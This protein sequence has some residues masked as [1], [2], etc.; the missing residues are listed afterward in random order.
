MASAE[1]IR[2]KNLQES[3]EALAKAINL[4]S[5][6]ADVMKD[7]VS[8]TKNRGEMDKSSL[9]LSRQAVQ[10]T[11]NLKGEYNSISDVQKDIAKNQSKSQDIQ[12]Q[13]LAISQN[14][15]KGEK[16]AIE[17]FKK[18][19][20]EA[21][22]AQKLAESLADKQ[23][24]G[25]NISDSQVQRAKD[26]AAIKQEE[27][28]SAGAS[29]S[30]QAEQIINLEQ[31]QQLLAEN[32]RYLEEQAE[33]LKN[34]NSAQGLFG[35]SLE[36]ASKLL[37]KVG[38]GSS[39][40]GKAFSTAAAK[41]KEFAIKA[42]DGGKKSLGAMG[43][44][45]VAAKG[46]GAALT[47]SLGPISIITGLITTI[48]SA[49]NKG[50]DAA[51]RL[52]DETTGLSRTL[53]VS[54]STA[55]ELASEIR[56]I[57]AEMGITGGDAIA[58]AGS[59]YSALD[60][61]ERL[62]RNTLA[63]FTK[64]NKFAG[65]T[66]DDIANIQKFSKLAGKEGAIVAEEMA[67]TARESIKANKLNVSMRGLMQAVGKQSAI[68]KLNTK[69]SA[70]ELVKQVAQA[71]KLGLEMSKVEDIA[72]SLLDFESSI[73]AE[74]EAELLTGKE[75]NLEKAREAALNGDNA[76]LMDEIASQ[77]GSIE[78]FQNMNR[79]GQEAFAKS[80]GMSR[81][82]LA[83]MLVNSKENTSENDQ[84][85]A[86]QENSLKAMQ[87]MASTSERLAAAEEARANK[88]AKIFELLNPIVETFKELSTV[89]LDV[90]TPIVEVLA[91][92]LQDIANTIVPI[93]RDYFAKLTPIIETMMTALEP[94]FK[95]LAKLAETILP[96]IL[97][98]MEMMAE[99]FGVIFE[100]L[101]P[102]IDIIVEGITP[103]I[104]MFSELFHDLLTPIKKIF[105]ALKEPIQKIA[106]AIEPIFEMLGKV[107][108]KILPI[109]TTLIEGISDVLEPVIDLFSS[110]LETLLPPIIK[111]IEN[112]LDALMPIFDI[113]SELV[114]MLMPVLVSLFETVTPII[115]Q[116]FELISPVFDLIA[117]LAT[118]VLPL[119]V[120]LFEGIKPI[121]DPILK[122]VK[123]I[124]DVIT[125]IL[126]GDFSK[127]ADGL[128]AIAS[129][130][131]N[132]ILAAI[133]FIL[134]APIKTF[135]Y[136]LDYIP[137]FGPDTFPLVSLPRVEFA[138]GG[139]VDRPTNA[140][141]GEAGPEAVVPLNSDKSLNVFS[142][143]LEAKLDILIDAVQQ[144]GTVT[145]DGQKVGEALVM[146]SYQLK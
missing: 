73:A 48:V 112:T 105:E 34:I 89:V 133:E 38:L 82:G 35:K 3:N 8:S 30:L 42:T 97:A 51:K 26:M 75:L 4:T 102:I 61:S 37:N 123:G 101:A 138:E 145:L 46:F 5:Q 141:I 140:L 108:E 11:R 117:E 33:R 69:G 87:S 68:V 21:Q 18:K 40:I 85:L 16:D 146:S 15:S 13:V 53:G 32:A 80:I 130:L 86:M 83:E 106:K 52:S 45:K 118:A 41:T 29:L 64:L 126:E 98:P 65:F 44:L 23:K 71:K 1:E 121:L 136:M 129:G 6:L 137:G 56:G 10:V 78:E 50:K 57:G 7:V 2:K 77:F 72:G 88:F 31:Q 94:I 127:V 66:A 92:I 14:L 113:I 22:K 62:S 124:F 39:V 19:N 109:F 55:N 142:K 99:L 116:I 90:I 67:T 125:G 120:S 79:I 122:V 96:L 9:D 134:N 12:K 110:L 111:M 36:G 59:I 95:T 131:I 143:T 76:T 70:Q 63:T 81:D 43:K 107:V 20:T 144:G 114:D 60:G 119:V 27:V 17:A 54:K 115:E 139:M 25:L 103:I 49:F 93:I 132:S 104:D 74:M 58:A 84:M 24:Q 47:T 28:S 135:N 128:K 91:P 100:A